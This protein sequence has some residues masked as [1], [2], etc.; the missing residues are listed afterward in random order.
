MTAAPVALPKVT[1]PWISAFEALVTIEPPPTLI[2]AAVLLLIGPPTDEDSSAS[3]QRGP[4]WVALLLAGPLGLLSGVVGIGGGIFLA[5]CLHLLRWDSSRRIA[6]TAAAFILVNSI[7]GIMGQAS[8]LSYSAFAAVGGAWWPCI[9][10]VL[11]AGQVGSHFGARRLSPALI[12]RL[13][14]VV[15]LFAGVRLLTA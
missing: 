12:R 14:A 11:I 15:I 4:G 3:R 13:T 6:G 8:K 9:A 5:P 1:V 2:A 7:A 10:A